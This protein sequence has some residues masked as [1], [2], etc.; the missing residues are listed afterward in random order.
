MLDAVGQKSS[1]D[2]TSV[3]DKR[4]TH[5]FAT[6]I[7]EGEY[8]E[9]ILFPARLFRSGLWLCHWWVRHTAGRGGSEVDHLVT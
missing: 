3:C 8:R 1:S 9:G 2:A 5:V 7:A 4:L 6:S